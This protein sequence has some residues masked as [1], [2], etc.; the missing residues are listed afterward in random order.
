MSAH[1]N[2]RPP[3]RAGVEKADIEDGLSCAAPASGLAP[4]L[5]QPAEPEAGG[6]GR[7]GARIRSLP[8]S[9]VPTPERV[10]AADLKRRT[11]KTAS[12]A[13]RRGPNLAMSGS[14]G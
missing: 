6:G 7:A 5:V 13:P 1:F 11:S 8:V 9:I 12:P 4:F 10:R 14:P 2:L 3:L